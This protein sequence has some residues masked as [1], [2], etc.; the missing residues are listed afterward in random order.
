MEEFQ[1]VLGQ[2]YAEE[3]PPGCSLR[4]EEQTDIRERQDKPYTS[5]EALDIVKEK[6]A[7]NF[8]R[9]KTDQEENYCYKL[10]DAEYYLVY[11]GQGASEDEYIIHL[12]EFV[13]ENPIENIGHT[14][15]YGWYR[16]DRYTGEITEE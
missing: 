14:V 10:P 13:T 16:I 8:I 15:T 12:Y 9:Q 5:M 4:E 11:E 2:I 6:Y 3:E 7:A 1:G